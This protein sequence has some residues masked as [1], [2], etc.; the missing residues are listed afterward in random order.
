MPE[1]SNQIPKSNC[2]KL[3][4][5]IILCPRMP[6]VQ[7][8]IARR[9]IIPEAILDF[10]LGHPEAFSYFKRRLKVRQGLTF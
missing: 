8:E 10:I 3:I 2:I 5:P 1:K 9:P 6:Q 4:F 7:F